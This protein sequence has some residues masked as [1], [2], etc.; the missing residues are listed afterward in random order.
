MR[1]SIPTQPQIKSEPIAYPPV[2]LKIRGVGNVVPVTIIFNGVLG[3][4]IGVTQKEVGK[5]IPGVETVE[6]EIALGLGEQIL[7][8]FVKR[9]TAAKLQLVLSLG[10]RDVI[11][12]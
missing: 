1:N 7:D 4:R 12:K 8:L 9:P 10:P 5:V 2:V 11:A 3:V 6:T